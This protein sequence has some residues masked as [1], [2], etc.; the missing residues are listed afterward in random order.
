MVEGSLVVRLLGDLEVVRGGDSVALPRSRR[1]R[2]L[3]GFLVAS[4]KA[5][6]RERLCDLLWDGPDDPR[7][8]LRWSLTKLRPLVDAPGRSRIISDRERA[9]FDTRDTYVDT[10]VFRTALTPRLEVATTAALQQAIDLVRGDFL[11][12][13]DLPQCYSWNAWL[14]GQRDEFRQL[15]RS[16][17]AALVMR[18]HD[19]PA[20]ALIAARRRAVLDPFA[21]DAHATVIE[22]LGSLGRVREMRAEYEACVRLMRQEFQRRPSERLEAARRRAEEACRA[23]PVDDSQSSAPSDSSMELTDDRH[24]RLIRPRARAPQLGP[25]VGRTGEMERLSA[26]AGI[27]PPVDVAEGPGGPRCLLVSG[28]PGIGKSR[29]LEELAALAAEHDVVVLRGRAYEAEMIRPYG[30]WTDALRPVVSE[31]RTARQQPAALARVLAHLGALLDD[32]QAGRSDGDAAGQHSGSVEGGGSPH[33]QN[34]F[35]AV[36]ELL[37]LLGRAGRTP[38]IV[39]DDLQWFD[40]AS[41]ALLHYVMRVASQSLLLA[42]SARVAALAANP[43]A[44]GLVRTLRRDGRLEEIRLG[45]L[46][47]AEIAQLIRGF[48]PEADV[49]RVAASA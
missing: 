27:A 10:T 29:L 16:A 9:G 13:L 18:L 40:D 20:E 14:A 25:M 46:P 6:R 43:A 36:V 38:L 21:E 49:S 47:A 12:G 31:M 41:I 22:L 11:V 32:S 3:L 4:G 26:V 33:R 24:L 2:A 45:P 48:A 17:L 23:V 42:A 8:A 37:Q 39:L 28:E 1:T 34:L 15:Q 30:P 35:D 44:S 7:A 5:E 19:R